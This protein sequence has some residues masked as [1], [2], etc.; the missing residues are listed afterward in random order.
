MPYEVC[1]SSF[2][3]IIELQKYI[4][5][6]KKQHDIEIQDCLKTYVFGRI[7]PNPFQPPKILSSMT[8]CLEQTIPARA[9]G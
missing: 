5:N 6:D 3:I 4:L 1:C 7:F 8:I 9:A 2:K